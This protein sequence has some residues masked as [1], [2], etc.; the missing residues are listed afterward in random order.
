MPAYSNLNEIAEILAAGLQRV[1]ARKSSQTSAEAGESSL[2]FSPEQS[3]HA[4]E[5]RENEA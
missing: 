5:F 2:D 4:P 3:G 1:I